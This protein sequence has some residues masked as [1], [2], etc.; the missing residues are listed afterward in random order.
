MNAPVSAAQPVWLQEVE[1][2]RPDHEFHDALS[3]FLLATLGRSAEVNNSRLKSERASADVADV[4]ERQG[5]TAHSGKKAVWLQNE[6]AGRILSSSMVAR[7]ACSVC[8]TRFRTRPKD[9]AGSKCN[10]TDL[11][12]AVGGTDAAAPCVRQTKRMAQAAA[13][14]PPSTQ[15]GPSLQR[16][17]A[18]LLV[19]Y[20][21][22]CLEFKW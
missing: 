4:Q 19:A 22:P 8:E 6:Q 17:C 13:D 20:E 2:T 21:I 1:Q 18:S 15:M 11:R 3:T 9:G 12:T 10:P 5:V 14:G 16:S 7:T